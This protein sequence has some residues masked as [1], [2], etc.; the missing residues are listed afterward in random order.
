MAN[1]ESKRPSRAD[2]KP[3]HESEQ[4]CKM[5]SEDPDHLTALPLNLEATLGA[6]LKLAREATGMSTRTVARRLGRR[7]PISHATVANYERGDSVP[8]MSVL[9]ALATLYDRQPNWFLSPQS[10]LEGVRYRN[11]K[12]RVSLRDR[13]VFEASCQR[14]LQ[15]YE[16]IERRFGDPLTP[17]LRFRARPNERPQSVARRLRTQLRLSEAEPLASVVEVLERLGV[18]VLEMT[19]DLAID[20]LAARLREAWVVVLNPAVSPDRGRMNAAHELGHL[21]RGLGPGEPSN[22]DEEMAFD[23]ASHLLMTPAMLREA[24][25]RRS[26]VDLVKYKERF[27]I[28]LAAM[29]YR[30]ERDEIIS[31]AV[32]KHLWIEFGKRGWRRNEPGRTLTDRAT[33]FEAIVDAAV[34]Q[35][36]TIESVAE[37]AGVRAEE[38][39]RRLEGAT[40]AD[41]LDGEI[42]ETSRATHRLRLAGLEPT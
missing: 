14:W 38:L 19:T 17:S 16:S 21:L 29:V 30:A 10:R 22:A 4:S 37:V 11:L 39:R 24:F 8:P 23:F 34:L 27:G 28:S 18:R 6:Q 5:A 40:G 32:A 1:S 9:A 2:V 3:V 42:Q 26:I 13:V 36:S 35:G 20:G 7:F 33:R 31:K 15:A 12:S 41:L 25:R